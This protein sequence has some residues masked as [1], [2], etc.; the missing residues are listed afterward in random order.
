MSFLSARSS[1]PSFC[2]KETVGPHRWAAI[3]SAWWALSSSCARGLPDRIAAAGRGGVRLCVFTYADPLY[4][5]DRNVDN[6]LYIQV[7]F[8]LVCCLFGLVTGHGQFSGHENASVEFLFRAWISPQPDD[9]VFFLL[10]GFASAFGGFFISQAYRNNE[11]GYI[12]PFEYIAMPL[13]IIWGYLVFQDWP[14][15]LCF[16]V[17]G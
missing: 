15:Q 7:T 5:Q 13:A 2:F 12:A 16:W 4:R 14:D 3:L 6:V 17:W 8:L 10:I 9:L 1:S 11:A